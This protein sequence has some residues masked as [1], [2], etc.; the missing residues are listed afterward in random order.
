MG[1]TV[2]HMTVA[3][4][5]ALPDKP[6]V[7]MELHDG[8]VFEMMYPKKR[9]WGV[10]ARI[11]KLLMPQLQKHGPVGTEF[12]FRPVPEYN[13]WAADVAFVT[14]SRWDATPLDDNLIGAPD[15]VIEVESPSN[16]ASEFERRERTCLRYGCREF[17]IVYPSLQAI[18]VITSSGETRH[19]ELGDTVELSIVP[20]VRVAL[21][22]I[23]DLEKI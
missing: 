11:M 5:R 13:L 7:R 16:T 2:G 14:Q 20:G 1:T 4:F 23:F 15:L 21:A 3:E 8:E 22:D 12:A 9:H 17:W 6:G 19:Y 18:R 10:Q